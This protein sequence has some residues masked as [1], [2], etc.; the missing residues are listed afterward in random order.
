VLS[1]RNRPKIIG[2]NQENF[3]PEYCFHIPAISGVFLPELVDTP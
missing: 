2:K 1:G 3:L